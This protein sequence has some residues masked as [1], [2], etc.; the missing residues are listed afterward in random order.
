MGWSGISFFEPQ[1]SYSGFCT[2]LTERVFVQFTMSSCYRYNLLEVVTGQNMKLF[3]SNEF[4]LQTVCC[5]VLGIFFGLLLDRPN[6]GSGLVN[7]NMHLPFWLVYL[8]LYVWVFQCVLGPRAELGHIKFAL[9]YWKCNS[10][11]ITNFL[12]RFLMVYS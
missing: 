5:S 3:A 6:A 11:F 7:L 4:C 8:T 9:I 10:I 12:Y 2:I 1:F